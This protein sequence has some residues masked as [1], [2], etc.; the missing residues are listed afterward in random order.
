MG[1]HKD[2]SPN[3]FFV[4]NLGPWKGITHEEWIREVKHAGQLPQSVPEEIADAFEIC[5]GTIMYGWLYYPLITVGASK[6]F[7]LRETMARIACTRY[8]ASKRKSETFADCIAYLGQ[9]GFI[10][11]KDADRWK[12]C[13]EIRNIWAHPDRQYILPPSHAL[14]AVETF[15]VDARLLFPDVAAAPGHSLHSKP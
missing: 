9:H 14:G 11:A 12:A 10:E 3:S 8:G 5:L 6:L 7:A 13:R 4:C 1:H 2:I 15:V